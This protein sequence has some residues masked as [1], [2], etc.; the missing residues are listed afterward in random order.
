MKNQSITEIKQMLDQGILSDETIEQLKLDS[1]KGVQQAVRSYQN[2]QAKQALLIKQF[3]AMRKYEE[4]NYLNGKQF[5]AGIDE[6]G[7]GPLAGPVVAAAVILPEN[8][9]LIGLTD[10][11]KLTVKQREAYAEII[12][13]QAVAIGIGEIS[14]QLI[15]EL[16]IYQ[17]SILAM[18]RA[19]D[20]LTVQPDHLLIDAVELPNLA[21]SSDVIIKGDQKS[22]SIAAA[23]VIAKVHRDQ[24]MAELHRTYPYY[25]FDQNQG[26]GTKG[27]L[28]GL[29]EHGITP[30]HRKSF[31][32]VKDKLKGGGGDGTTLF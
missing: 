17:A 12:K 29:E 20:Q 26:Y 2:K 32:P 1:R 25:Q 4:K 31:A 13:Q 19:V 15:D 9:T 30:F 11:K 28:Q 22:I 18:E 6:V 8:F 21:Y 24:M 16:N 3:Q 23:S 5:I 7:R 14:P 27:H 10:S